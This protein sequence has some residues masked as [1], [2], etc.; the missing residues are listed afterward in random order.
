MINDLNITNVLFI[1]M[2]NILVTETEIDNWAID[3]KSKFKEITGDDMTPEKE[4][5]IRHEIKRKIQFEK[6]QKD[7]YETNRARIAQNKKNKTK[8]T[9]YDCSICSYKTQHKGNINAHNKRMH[10][11]SSL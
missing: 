2:N 9:N 4:I 8:D 3:L 6:Y 11:N 5:E 10:S 1:I 7:Y